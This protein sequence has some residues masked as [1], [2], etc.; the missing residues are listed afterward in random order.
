MVARTAPPT[1]PLAKAP[2]PRAPTRQRLRAKAPAPP[3]DFI[4]FQ[5]PKLVESP[6]SGAGWIHEVKFDGYR[7]Q[8]R[9]ARGAAQWRT[10]TGLDWTARFKDLAPLFKGMPDCILDGELCVL[11][12]KGQPDFSALRSAMGRRQAGAMAG[13]LVYFVFD[14]L[15]AGGEDLTNLPL[16]DRKARLAA[17][18]EPDGVPVSDRL[19]RVEPIDA[20]AR[21]LFSTA[22]AMGLEGIVCKRADATYR[23][24][25][26]SDTWVKIKCRPAQEVVV[27]GWKTTGDR[28]RSLLAGVWEGGA[29]RY[30]GSVHT[31][32]SAAKVAELMPSLRAAQAKTSPFTAGDPPRKTSEIHWT[33]PDLVAAIE[34]EG[35]TSAGKIRQ[36]SYKGLREDKPAADVIEE[37]PAPPA[38]TRATPKRKPKS[39]RLVP[40]AVQAPTLTHGD[41]VLWPATGGQ[42]PIGKADLAA[43]YEAA[44]DW[45]L[46]YMRGRPC[47]VLVAPDG[48]DG[49]LVYQRHEGQRIGGL[50][51]AAAV[52]HVPIAGT[53]HVVSQFDTVEALVAAAQ[54]DA[55][56]LHPWN[57]IPEDPELPGRF[58]FDLDPDEGLPFHQVVEAAHELRDRLSDLGLASWLKTSGGKGLHLVTPFAQDPKAPIDWARAKAFARAV[59]AAMAADSPE[60]YTIAL[61]KAQ[62]RGRVFLDYLRTDRTRHAAG[63]LSPRATPEATVSMPLS[64][65]QAR[66]GLDPTAFTLRNALTQLAQSR[67]WRD[68][69]QSPPP[70][71]SAIARLRG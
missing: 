43:Y 61:P 57:G 42:A 37:T 63:L 71:A 22:C 11:D 30:V 62:R 27:G 23:S 21:Q 34:F 52:T 64:W 3:P 6:P 24:G 51:D 49:E 66:P 48:V 40:S 38:E 41:K 20:E 60:R 26:R 7:M 1:S 28:F 47:T 55:I 16:S 67:A 46:P 56:E 69:D 68:Y 15:F 65:R 29:L 33:R 9:V 59:C 18:L 2:P 35:W 10:R 70:L 32:Y 39:R 17:M 5:H 31:G 25:D 19:R 58:V 50:R 4:A 13:S 36:A 44:A 8:V 53:D 54:V 45:L 12:A 14:L